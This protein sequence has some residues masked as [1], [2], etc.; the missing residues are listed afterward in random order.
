MSTA[1]FEAQGRIAQILA[2]LE[3]KTGMIV[4]RIGIDTIDTAPL[5]QAVPS[6]TR[7]VAITLRPLPGTHWITS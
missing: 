6:N 7:S 2:D 5:G 4:E 3:V 1:V